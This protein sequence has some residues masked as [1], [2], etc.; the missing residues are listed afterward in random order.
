M[1]RPFFIGWRVVTVGLVGAVG[2]NRE[3][4]GHGTQRALFAG[5]ACSYAPTSS[6]LNCSSGTGRLYK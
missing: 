5:F 4:V 1:G 2:G 6:S 3:Q